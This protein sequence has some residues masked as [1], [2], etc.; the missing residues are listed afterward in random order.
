MKDA[1][2]MLQYMLADAWEEG[3]ADS[4]F[5]AYNKLQIHP[6]VRTNVSDPELENI[7]TEPIIDILNSVANREGL[8]SSDVEDWL[9]V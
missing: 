4:I 1:L 5:K 8:S 7:S 2:Y 6:N 9:N 3:S